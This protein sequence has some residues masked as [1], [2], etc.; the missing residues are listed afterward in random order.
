VGGKGRIKT[1]TVLVVVGIEPLDAAGTAEQTRILK[2]K[3]TSH[4]WVSPHPF[5]PKEHS[6]SMPW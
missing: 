6:L 2:P 3:P 5:T 4:G 1:P